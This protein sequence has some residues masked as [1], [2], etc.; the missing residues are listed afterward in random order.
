MNRFLSIDDWLKIVPTV[1]KY[2]DLCIDD[3]MLALSGLSRG[4]T[5]YVD[6][7]PCSCESSDRKSDDG[8]DGNSDVELCRLDETVGTKHAGNNSNVNNEP[9]I[10]V[11]KQIS[12]NVLEKRNDDQPAIAVEKPISYNVLE[13]RK[14]DQLTIAAEK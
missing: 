4:P 11:E 5:K 13:K 9:T 7:A 3:A 10:S 2:G 14:Y 8:S 12:Y 1:G 6:I